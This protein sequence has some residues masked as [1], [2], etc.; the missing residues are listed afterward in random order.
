MRD[1]AGA[2]PD[3]AEQWRTNQNQRYLAFRT[4]AEILAAKK[5]LR[6]GLTVQ[7][8]ADLNVMQRNRRR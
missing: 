8:A 6:P 7:H 3:M 4:L 5:A 1:A 2:D